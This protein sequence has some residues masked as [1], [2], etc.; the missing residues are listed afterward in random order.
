MNVPVR[1]VCCTN[2]V[3]LMLS[4][5]CTVI[6]I[7]STSCR[8]FLDMNTSETAQNRIKYL[9]ALLSLSHCQSNIA[10][11]T[12]VRC[13]D[14][15][16]AHGTI[17]TSRIVLTCTYLAHDSD[18]MHILMKDL[19]TPMFKYPSARLRAHDVIAMKFNVK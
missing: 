6:I 14:G 11:A 15:Y 10:G 16:G 3:S 4:C 1:V 2:T 9:E 17:L 18:G 8:V 7:T 19:N 5:L 12:T 13:C